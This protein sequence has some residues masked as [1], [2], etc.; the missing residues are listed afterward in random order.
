MVVLCGFKA[1]F[2][3]RAGWIALAALFSVTASL[4]RPG[5]I[6]LWTIIS[7]W[8]FFY[9]FRGEVWRGGRRAGF[10]LFALALLLLMSVPY[11]FLFTEAEG[12]ALSGD[13]SLGSLKPV[14]DL[15]KSEG[16]GLKFYRLFEHLP[17]SFSVPFFV[18]FVYWFYR[19][20]REGFTHTE[21][22]FLSILVT[23]WVMYGFVN[24]S[25]RIFSHLMPAGMPLAA[26][27]FVYVERWLRE[28]G[29]AAAVPQLIAF[30][31]VAQLVTG[32]TTLKAH[33]LTEKVAGNWLRENGGIGAAI[34]SRK[35]IVV[36]YA[37]GRHVTL[38]AGEMEEVVEYGKE[39]GAKYLAGYRHRLAEYLSGFEAGEGKYLSE[40]KSF[41]GE[42][43]REFVIYSFR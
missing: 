16:Y 14:M 10:A 19:R 17:E 26:A 24:P 11:L 5:G 25:R 42:K 15:A 23:F 34:L 33:H 12:T 27:G 30:L 39:R 6:V 2:T 28:R 43:G 32:I 21:Y 4:T 13:L 7:A 22:F 35:P 37:E 38:R 9:T 29:R 31:V 41:K 40:I 3:G 18:F 1:V 20:I 36:F 8:V